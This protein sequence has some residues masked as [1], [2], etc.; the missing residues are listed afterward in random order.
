MTAQSNDIKSKKSITSV[1]K[2]VRLQER[3]HL[4]HQSKIQEK[5]LQ[6]SSS[7]SLMSNKEICS[8]ISRRTIAIINLSSKH[9]Q[10][11]INHFN[12]DRKQK[13]KRSEEIEQNYT[14]EIKDAVCTSF[15]RRKSFIRKHQRISSAK[16]VIATCEGLRD[17]I[18]HRDVNSI[19]R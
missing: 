8:L 7:I 3:K 17:D 15:Q 10:K 6:L 19:Q 11:S 4:F 16:R 1:R 12:L 9:S 13:R 5:L 2:R 18:K 14:L